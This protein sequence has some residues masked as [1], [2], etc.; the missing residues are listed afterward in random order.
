MGVARQ[1]QA[2]VAEQPCVPSLRPTHPSHSNLTMWGFLKF[3]AAVKLG[4]LCDTPDGSSKASSSSS[5]SSSKKGGKK[6]SKK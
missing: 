6:G 2:I 1:K 3:S 4:E 5:K